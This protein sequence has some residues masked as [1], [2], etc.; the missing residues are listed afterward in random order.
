MCCSK[1]TPYR[2]ILKSI[3]LNSVL[4][5]QSL[6]LNTNKLINIQVI[7]DDRGCKSTTL[8]IGSIGLKL[9]LLFQFDD[10]PQCLGE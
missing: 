4:I 1:F 10:N 6:S 3:N 8:L 5:F 2:L 9:V 7:I